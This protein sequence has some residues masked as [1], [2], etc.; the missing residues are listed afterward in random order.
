MASGIACAA[1][2]SLTTTDTVVSERPRWVARVR[3]VTLSFLSVVFLPVNCYFQGVFQKIAEG[4][5][6]LDFSPVKR[7]TIPGFCYLQIHV[8]YLHF[9]GIKAPLDSP[10][11]AAF[12]SCRFKFTESFLLFKET[13]LLRLTVVLGASLSSVAVENSAL[14]SRETPG[15]AERPAKPRK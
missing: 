10:I 5:S 2:E 1:G 15:N 3:R 7:E 4:V 12:Y 13:I 11:I 8:A 14:C 9:Q 6:H